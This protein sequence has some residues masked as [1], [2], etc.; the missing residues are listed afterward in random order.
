MISRCRSCP[1]VPS[2]VSRRISAHPLSSDN[3]KCSTH[4]CA[5][6]S[7]GGESFLHP[8]VWQRVPMSREGSL[9]SN[10][11]GRENPLRTSRMVR[12][13]HYLY[14]PSLRPLPAPP[15]P[16]NPQLPL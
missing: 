12:I 16:D 11:T 4:S 10:I 8:G 5:S 7:A 15:P 13:L 9:I 1:V 3:V 14:F 2:A 6:A